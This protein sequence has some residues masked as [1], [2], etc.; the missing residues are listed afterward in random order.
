MIAAEMTARNKGTIDKTAF[1]LYYLLS[2]RNSNYVE[3]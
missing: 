3:I 1:S 2:I